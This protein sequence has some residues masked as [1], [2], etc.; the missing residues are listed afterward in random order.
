MSASGAAATS[1]TQ[2][3]QGLQSQRSVIDAAHIQQFQS[4][5]GATRFAAIDA[6]VQATSTVKT[7]AAPGI[8]G[9]P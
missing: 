4:A 7:V 3:I 5:V 9:K 2:Q 8:G 6:A 1:L